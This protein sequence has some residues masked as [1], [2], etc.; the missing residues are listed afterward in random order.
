[1]NTQL[2][3]RVFAS[4]KI[5][6]DELADWTPEQ[7][8]AF[9]QGLTR[10]LA[11]ADEAR[12]RTSKT[13]TIHPGPGWRGRP[14]FRTLAGGQPDRR[15]IY[16]SP[17]VDVAGNL[18]LVR[19][20]VE[21]CRVI[22]ELTNWQIRLLSKSNL[23]PKIAEGLEAWWHESDPKMP[24]PEMPPS[25]A[26]TRD[27]GESGALGFYKQATRSL[28]IPFTANKGYSSSSAMYEASK[29]YVERAENGK[30]LYIVYLGDHDPSGID[31]SRDVGSRLDLFVKTATNRCD[32]IGPNELD[33]VEVK[34]VALNMDQIEELRPP[35][36]PAKITDSRANAYI[37]R[38]GHSSWELD[39]IEPRQLA[40]LVTQ[41][42]TALMDVPLF[43]RN[44]KKQETGRKALL[45]FAKTYLNGK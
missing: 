25:S 45:K 42:V 19:E 14:K 33:A 39:A 24:F 28:D 20:T 5:N 2:G 36:N 26:A 40:N 37:Q 15:V 41:A 22:L 11:T 17:L 21:I 8:L 43:K 7:R 16:A 3:A 12:D 4:V 34:R 9:Y 38:F 30:Q 35:E 27:G 23:L 44:E 6:L 13:P 29:R 32:E 18:E 31:M 10:V 1:M